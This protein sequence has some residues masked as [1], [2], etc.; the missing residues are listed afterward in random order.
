MAVRQNVVLGLLKKVSRSFYVSLR[1]L[2]GPMRP[3]A[4]LAYLLART[5]DTIADSARADC[6]LRLQALDHFSAQIN[7]EAECRSWPGDLILAVKD[8]DERE[9][10]TMSHRLVEWS[11]Q[12]PA[13]EQR[14][15][16][17]VMRTIISG[18]RY[19][20]ELFGA[21]QA[22]QVVVMPS[23]RQLDDYTY[24]VAGCVGEFWT[25]LGFETMGEDYSKSPRERLVELAVDYGKGLQMVNILRDLPRDLAQGRCY[26][27]VADPANTDDLL[28]LHQQQCIHAR[29]LVLNGF[30]Y[31][32]ELHG[33]RLRMASVL[34]AMLA[35][36]TLDLLTD[37][38]WD[39]LKAGVKITRSRVYANLLG[40]LF[41]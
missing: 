41:F 35:K 29:E 31:A 19:D 33:R 10:L 36:D 26:L 3:S 6:G 32:S 40:S 21:A 28:K 24:R 15:I 37:A 9:L 30:T 38:D 12:T 39:R 22:D 13:G 1:L 23:A 16:K 2:P 7:G 18:Q 5:S 11:R 4:G 27:P 17:E 8:E 20:L 25:R 34:P 14:L